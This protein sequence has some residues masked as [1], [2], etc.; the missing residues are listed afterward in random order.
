MVSCQEPM[1]SNFQVT[2][3]VWLPERRT[4]GFAASVNENPV[5]EHDAVSG[6]HVAAVTNTL[7]LSV[8]LLRVAFTHARGP[9]AGA[10]HE[11]SSAAQVAAAPTGGVNDGALAMS[12]ILSCL[13]AVP[14]TMFCTVIEALFAVVDVATL[15]TSNVTLA[16]SVTLACSLTFA[17][18][19]VVWFEFGKVA[20]V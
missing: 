18:N 13:V 15:V 16:G 7:L 19:V 17:V 1:L 9:L 8:P 3:S 6:A 5:V 11:T 4:V 14:S 10:D 12:E 20:D 2:S